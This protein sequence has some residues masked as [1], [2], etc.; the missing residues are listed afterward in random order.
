MK[1]IV[2]FYQNNKELCQL[3]AYVL[4]S[5]ISTIVLCLIKKKKVVNDMDLIL[6][7]VFER[8]PGLINDAEPF[9]GA[10]LKKSLVME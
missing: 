4:V 1:H 3:I 5:V 8:L 10:E 2:E 9:K 7:E 6:K